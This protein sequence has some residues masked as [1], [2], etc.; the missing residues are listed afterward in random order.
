MQDGRDEAMSGLVG[1]ACGVLLVV[2]LSLPRPSQA[3]V[4]ALVYDPTN[5][6]ANMAQVAQSI[7]IVANQIL[8]LTAIGAIVI[9]AD[10][11]FELTETTAAATAL[12]YPP[13]D[14]RAQ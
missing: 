2:L 12:H 10:D 1:R 5:W 14:R 3:Q 13:V 4:A 8:D 9:A 6:A 7:L 11:V